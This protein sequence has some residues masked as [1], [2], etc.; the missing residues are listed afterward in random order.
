MPLIL[1]QEELSNSPVLDTPSL[2]KLTRGLFC[3]IDPVHSSE[4]GQFFWRAKLSSHRFYAVK[5]VYCNNK[6]TLIFMHRE[7]MQTPLAMDCHHINHNTLDNRKENLVNLTRAEHRA[8]HAGH[9]L[10]L[11][12]VRQ[13]P[14]PCLRGGKLS[15]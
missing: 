13:F 5:R 1:N 12:D 9:S 11:Y 10:S 3:R 8:L 7:I 4:L 14:P 2:I 15:N 6:C